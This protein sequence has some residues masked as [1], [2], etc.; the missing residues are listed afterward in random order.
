LLTNDYAGALREFDDALRVN[1]RT[2][3]GAAGFGSQ[4]SS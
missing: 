4:V 2:S 3:L 1:P